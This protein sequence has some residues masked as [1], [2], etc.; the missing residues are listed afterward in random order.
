[1]KFQLIIAGM[2]L[3]SLVCN[4]QVYNVPQNQPS[5]KEEFL[6]SEPDF[7]KASNWLESTAIDKESYSRKKTNAWVIVWITNS[8]TVTVNMHANVLKPFDKNP[9]LLAVFM[10]GYAR[11]VIENNYDKDDFNGNLAG[12]KSAIKCAN[13]GGDLKKDKNLASLID[14]EKSGKLEEWLKNALE[15]K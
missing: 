6:K 1:M 3:L 5:T 4:S 15:E 9:D 7:I 12:I 10:A 13:L 14:S 11:Y 2:L 8:P